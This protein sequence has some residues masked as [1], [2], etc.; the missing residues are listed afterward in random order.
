MAHQAEQFYQSIGLKYT[1]VRSQKPTGCTGIYVNEQ[2]QNTIIISESAMEDLRLNRIEEQLK[3]EIA[4]A[5]LI[6]FQSEM[7]FE[8]EL[9]ILKFCKANS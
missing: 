1:A 4:G 2:G 5:Q 3:Q 9:E 8:A 7:N 6:V